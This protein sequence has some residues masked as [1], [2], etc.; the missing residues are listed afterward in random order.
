MLTRDT[1]QA[2]YDQ[3]PDAVFTLFTALEQR[4]VELEARLNKDSHNSS[5]PPSS[6]GL[7]KK[8]TPRSL[9]PKTGRKQGG[10]KGHPGKT[11][12]LSQT[13]DH[14]VPHIPACCCGCGAS[15]EGAEVIGEQRRQ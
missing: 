9:R 6:D 2:L 15:L 14:R 12:T 10:Q 4:V 1:F 8:P 11:L 13:P 3:G 5:K 7:K